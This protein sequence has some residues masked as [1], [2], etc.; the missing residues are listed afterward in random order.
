MSHTILF[1]LSLAQKLS[2]L[3]SIILVLV[4]GSG[5]LLLSNWLGDRMQERAVNETT[6]INRQVMDMIDAYASVLEEMTRSDARQLLGTMGN[7]F[8]VTQAG[9]GGAM[10]LYAGGQLLND[11]AALVDAFSQSTHGVATFM[12]RQG[13][14]FVRVASSLKQQDGRRAVGTA[15]DHTHPA[16]SLLLEGRTFTGP[17]TLFGRS[18]MTHYLPLKN[19]AGEVIGALFVGIDN[20]DGLKAL[21]DKILSLKVG[22]TGY[23]YVLDARATPG[24]IIIHPTSEGKN[25]LNATDAEGNHY[26]QSMFQQKNGFIYYDWADAPD[27]PTKRKMATF[28]FYEH[29][30]WI[31][32]TSVYV[33][34]VVKEKH[35]VQWRLL[36]VSFAIVVLLLVVIFV[37]LKRWV[38]LPLAQVVRV[39]QQVAEGNLAVSVDVDRGDEVGQVLLATGQMCV[40][41]R[42][43][44]GEVN[45]SVESL[46]N[47]AHQLSD[48]SNSVSAGAQSQSESVAAMAASVEEMTASIGQVNQHAGV[49]KEMAKQSGEVSS[50]GADVV[51]KTVET[52]RGI[53]SAS[54]LTSSTVVSLEEHAESISQVVTVIREI[55]DQ[56]NLLAL[57]AAIEA[58]RAGTAGR[59]FAV[60]ADE[61][62]KLAERTTQSTFEISRMVNEIQTGSRTAVDNMNTG[63]DRVNA[64][65]ALATEAGERLEGIRREAGHVEEAITG[66]SVALNQQSVASMDIAHNVEKVA[67]QAEQNH[68]KASDVALAACEMTALAQQLHS[69]VARF[70]L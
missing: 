8:H 5:T 32:A 20:T 16:Y 65:M 31:V 46:A 42:K 41:L 49:A 58:A 57:N 27:K 48:L 19:Q 1:R 14:D 25:V 59:G 53:S 30:G 12:V 38:S 28:G 67:Q 2:L 34:E 50:R 63:I 68:A 23:V 55:A 4:L 45:Q 26:I 43:L 40:E 51:E 29:W 54:Q 66:I 22:D 36:S 61:V 7:S 24:N 35:Q 6:Q 52:M 21:R 37:A 13:S 18:Y 44:I 69:S 17:A 62:R 15:L 33:D 10:S 9:T 11:N 64:G 60:V 56:T 39:T 70:R 3:L 47:N